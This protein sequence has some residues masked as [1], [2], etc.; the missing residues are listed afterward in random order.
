MSNPKIFLQPELIEGDNIDIAQ[1]GK[2]I[3]SNTPLANITD[4]D[5]TDFRE[6]KE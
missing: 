2:T 1:D 6:E 4:T 5:I 3:S